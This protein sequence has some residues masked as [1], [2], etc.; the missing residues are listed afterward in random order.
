MTSGDLLHDLPDDLPEELVETL[1]ESGSVRIERVV[2]TGHA[3]PEGF[4]YDQP[5]LEF[6]LVVK[7]RA[8]LEFDDGGSLELEPGRW[9]DIPAHRRHRVAWT[10]PDEPTVWLA[11]H[12]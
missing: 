12:F 7:G 8:R 6:V 10:S 9:F 11:I 5:D 4:W 1:A 2:S 3:S